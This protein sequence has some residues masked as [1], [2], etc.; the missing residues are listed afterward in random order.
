MV[1]TV[2]TPCQTLQIGDED[3]ITHIEI[4]Y[5][6]ETLR[7]LTIELASGEIREFGERKTDST[8]IDHKI[9]NFDFKNH[10]DLLGVFGRIT[11]ATESISESPHIHSLGFIVN[12]CP[13]RSLLDFEQ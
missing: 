12:E 7:R 1:G 5:R 9:S 4:A 8:S 11:I 3:K 6:S 10:A 13:V 2:K